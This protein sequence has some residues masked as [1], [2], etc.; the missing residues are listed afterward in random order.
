MVLGLKGEGM[1]SAT[2]FDLRARARLGTLV[3]DGSGAHVYASAGASWIVVP[4]DAPTSIGAIV[5]FGAAVGHPV[6]R[7]VFITF[8][9]GYQFGFQ[10]ATLDELN[11]D[12]ELSS[13][14]FHIGLGIGSC[15]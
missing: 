11:R 2:Q 7:S 14:L 4:G 3:S 12:I 13:R 9:L 8:E 15:L 6:D 5:G 1:D 10:N